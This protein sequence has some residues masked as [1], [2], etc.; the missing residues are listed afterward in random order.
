LVK[1]INEEGCDSQDEL[2]AG[3]VAMWRQYQQVQKKNQKDKTEKKKKIPS[4]GVTWG[5]GS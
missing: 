1:N 5:N 3:R 4:A 2:R